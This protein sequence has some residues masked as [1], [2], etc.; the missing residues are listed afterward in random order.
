[1]PTINTK[2]FTSAMAGAPSVVGNIGGGL[3]GTLT[4][5][6]KDGFN[7]LTLDSLVVAGNVATGTKAG[8]GFIVDQVVL[9]AG[10]S[11]AGLNGEWRVSSV[12]SS[13]VM[14]NTTGI[15]DQTATG[16]I[17]IKAAPCGWLVPYTGTN[18]A[19]FKSGDGTSTQLPVRVDD[20][21]AQYSAIRG[22]ENFTDISTEVNGY[23]THY[24]K[25]SNATDANARPWLVVADGKTVYFGI[26]WTNAGAYDFY[27]FGDFDSFV[28][29]D[30]ANFRLQG[31][32]S[33]APAAL[34]YN[35]S[36]SDAYP[37]GAS[38]SQCPRAYTQIF[39]TIAIGQLSVAAA[40][41]FLLPS[42]S[43]QTTYSFA[44]SGNHGY[45]NTGGTDAASDFWS[46]PGAADN[47]YHFFPVYL[48][49]NSAGGRL[50]R[51][52]ARG[53]LHVIEYLPQATGYSILGA[54]EN[55]DGGKVL[56]AR[57]NGSNGANS[58]SAAST[59]AFS[60]GDW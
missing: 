58:Y 57:S 16:T 35:S 13:T 50:L 47:G 14:F 1:M 7:L 52:K 34:G 21:T 30:G 24:A 54:V 8:H 5:C 25:R 2:W 17:T 11:P 23:A 4:A 6:L 59:V 12:T 32:V 53:L 31:L 39:G 27:S 26:Q 29:G 44:L 9:I 46:T 60:L 18:Q 41:A 49:E 56:M 37:N 19:V 45:R 20:T 42:G 15:S 36:V 40:T 3:I 22:A 48:S 33:S 55:V 43:A 38:Y 51:G 10:A 28:A